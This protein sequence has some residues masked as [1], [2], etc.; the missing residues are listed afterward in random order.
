MPTQPAPGEH[1]HKYKQEKEKVATYDVG[2][3]V[4]EISDPLAECD[5]VALRV[6]FTVIFLA[7]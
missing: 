1:R 7:L 3:G 2:A 6:E 4:S 5:A